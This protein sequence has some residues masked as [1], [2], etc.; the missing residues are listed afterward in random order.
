MD[1]RLI[2]FLIADILLVLILFKWI[3]NQI[4]NICEKIEGFIKFVQIMFIGFS[5]F[6]FLSMFV[7]YLIWNPEK[8][9]QILTVFLTI[10]V[11]FLGTVMGL[12]FST[13]AL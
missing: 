12:F 7:Y 5:W 2:C 13:E 3:I 11:G 1:L 9:T 6:V 10:V 4:R 8:E